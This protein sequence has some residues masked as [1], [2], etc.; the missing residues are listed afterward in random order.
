MSSSDTASGTDYLK[1]CLVFEARFTR[2]LFC[3][4]ARTHA[5]PDFL[6]CPAWRYRGTLDRSGV[7]LR[8]LTTKAAWAAW[9]RDGFHVFTSS[10]GQAQRRGES[11]PCSAE[12]CPGP[13]RRR[14]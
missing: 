9:H 12:T 14:R 1:A 6:I 13:K 8:E 10:I 5:I 2:D 11:R 3:L 7:R 4:V